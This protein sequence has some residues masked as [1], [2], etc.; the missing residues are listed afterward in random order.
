M[1]SCLISDPGNS[2]NM[3][4]IPQAKERSYPWTNK[5]TWILNLTNF[6]FLFITGFWTFGP[7]MRWRR[8]QRRGRSRLNLSGIGE[9]AIWRPR[10]RLLLLYSNLKERRK[11]NYIVA[12]T[13]TSACSTEPWQT[14]P[15][16]SKKVG[17]IWLPLCHPLSHS[18]FK[19][20]QNENCPQNL[21]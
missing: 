19:K 1:A 7:N 16:T 20:Q 12:S 14:Q 5:Q 18:F 10:I 3:D 2:A 17:R 13:R 9:K 11:K 15:R 6:S 4:S 21:W 8:R